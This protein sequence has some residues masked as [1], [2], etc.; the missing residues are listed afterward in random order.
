MF[1]LRVVQ[2]LHL[3]VLG[4]LGTHI[5]VRWCRFWRE[6]AAR[7]SAALQEQISAIMGA[8]AQAA[9]AEICELVAGGYSLLQMEISRSRRENQDLKKKLHL[10]ESI[11]VRGG[12][13]AAQPQQPEPERAA[14]A[15][16]AEEVEEVE[17]VSGMSAR[18]CGDPSRV[19]TGGCWSSACIFLVI[20][21]IWSLWGFNPEACFFFNRFPRV[22]FALDLEL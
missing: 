17:E 2:D 15:G 13:G 12:S 11:V 21:E 22:H 8:L 10:I 6:M 18:C 5:W 14:P 20:A 16:G 19:K 1:P 3:E 9:V 4:S 7:N